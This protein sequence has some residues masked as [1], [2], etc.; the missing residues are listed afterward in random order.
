MEPREDFEAKDARL[1]AKGEEI[2]ARLPYATPGGLEQQ[3]LMQRLTRLHNKRRRLAASRMER[4]ADTA[5]DGHPMADVLRSVAADARAACVA[6]P[7][8]RMPPGI[9]RASKTVGETRSRE[10]RQR[11]HVA[12]STSSA[13]SGDDGPAPPWPPRGLAVCPL[14][15]NEAAVRPL[16]P[17]CWGLGYVARELRN[18]WKRGLR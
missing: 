17:L 10:R 4:V 12:R 6:V 14:C 9:V 5:S 15:T 8:V 1:A 7:V 13:D 2:L 11:R 18:R 3:I 16:C